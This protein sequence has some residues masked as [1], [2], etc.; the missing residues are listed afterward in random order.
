M[1]SPFFLF[2]MSAC[3]D[4]TS[5]KTG[6]TW[7]RPLQADVEEDRT[8]DTSNILAQRQGTGVV[9]IQQQLMHKHR[10]LFAV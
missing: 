2:I 10:L 5:E 6:P 4:T 7:D 1:V 8:I 3:P 9:D